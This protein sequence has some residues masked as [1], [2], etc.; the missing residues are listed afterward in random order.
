MIQTR[1]PAYQMHRKSLNLLCFEC[2]GVFDVEVED[3]EECGH[4]GPPTLESDVYS[5]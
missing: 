1:H 4:Q 3:P 2:G 5:L